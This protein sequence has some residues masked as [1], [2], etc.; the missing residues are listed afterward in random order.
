[1]TDS[2]NIVHWNC[3]GFNAH[4]PEYIWS[5]SK[6]KHIPDIICLQ[7]V[8]LVSDKY[9]VSIFSTLSLTSNILTA[10]SVKY[11]I[12]VFGSFI[13][14]NFPKMSAKNKTISFVLSVSE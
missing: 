9:L 3:Q 10:N 6:Q 13:L 8:Q 14:G 12:L 7:E 2:V 11:S 1:M 5:L 4:G